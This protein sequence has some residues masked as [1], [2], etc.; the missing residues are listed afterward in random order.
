VL[1][2]EGLLY[3]AEVVLQRLGITADSVV[4]NPLPN[5]HIAGINMLLV[6]LYTGACGSLYAEFDP[7]QFIA[8]I[9]AHGNHAR[10]LVPAMVMFSCSRRR[11]L[12]ATTTAQVIAY[13]ARRVSSAC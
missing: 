1:T 12:A 5:F 7:A 9:G 6:T 2:H 4:G 10:L 13:G 8:A 3:S 11:R